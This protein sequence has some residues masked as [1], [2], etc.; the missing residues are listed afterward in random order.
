MSLADPKSP[1]CN[2]SRTNCSES[3]LRVTSMT[4]SCP[5][6]LFVSTN[7]PRT[8]NCRRALFQIAGHFGRGVGGGAGHFVEDALEIFQ[9]GGRDDDGV[10]AAIDVFGDAQETAA[11]IFL[12]SENESFAFD[13]DFVAA[14]GVFN[15]TL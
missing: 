4:K 9:A 15:D 11:R 3:G 7:H 2:F 12:Q 10:A 1:L 13:L 8:E 14:Q 6:G 5:R